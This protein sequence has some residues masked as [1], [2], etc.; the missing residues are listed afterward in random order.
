[1][2]EASRA[3]RDDWLRFSGGDRTALDRWLRD[4][5]GRPFELVSP[6]TAERRLLEIVDRHLT[7]Q[8]LLAMARPHRR[9]APGAQD[10]PSTCA[11]VKSRPSL[12]V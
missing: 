12:R 8:D 4:Q 6:T 1:M 2:N 3:A 7:L 11:A 10:T 5:I 9:P